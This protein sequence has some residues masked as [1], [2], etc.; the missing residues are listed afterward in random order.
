MHNS[1]HAAT[2]ASTAHLARHLHL[3]GAA[4][5]HAARVAAQRL[6]R[7]SRRR[8]QQQRQH[9]HA[10]QIMCDVCQARPA[11]GEADSATG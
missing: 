7:G 11:A 3:A 1:R 8:Q 10:R 9:E 4:S 2:P 5:G 6:L